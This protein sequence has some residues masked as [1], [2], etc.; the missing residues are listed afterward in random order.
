[1]IDMA[2]QGVQLIFI[3]SDDFA[4]DAFLVAEKHSDITF[5]HVSGDHVLTGEAPP[6]L[7]NYMG[8]MEYTKM[9]AA[10]AATLA[11]DTGAIGYLRPLNNDET[12]RLVNTTY[13][14]ASYCYEHFR[15]QNPAELHSKVKWIGFWFHIPGVTADPTQ[16]SNDL[17]GRG[18]EVIISGIDAHEALI[19]SDERAV[20]GERV[21]AIPYDYEGACADAP[22]VCLGVPYFNWGPGYL[23]IAQIVIDGTWE[24]SWEWASPDW[25]D[26]NNHDTSTV[27]FLEGSALTG[28]QSVQLEQF[29]SDL[30][31]G[32]LVLFKGPL[33]YQD[34]ILFLTEGEIASEKQIWHMSQLLIRME[35]LSE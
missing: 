12:R 29:R 30:A 5:I 2:T 10:S 8:R 17:F 4:V 1:M 19:V 20:A 3:T 15:H 7:G 16:V 33:N 31:D 25:D 28:K 32:S 9:I 14:G 27:S 6:N 21:L 18:V 11:T 13:L 34:G 24:Q 22:Q 35:G 23:T 26:I